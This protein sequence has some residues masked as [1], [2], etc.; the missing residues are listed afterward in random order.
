MES[1]DDQASGDEA[2]REEAWFDRAHESLHG[3]VWKTA[4]T[5]DG[6]M[7]PPLADDVYQLASGSVSA[8]VL[9]D[10]FHGF[11]ARARFNVDVPL[12]RINERLHLFVG[13]YDPDEYVTER[14][15]TLGV[16]PAPG[17]D[18]GEMDETLA[19]LLYRRDRKDGTSLSGSVGG[20]VRSG[21]PDP[22]AKVS[23]EIRRPFFDDTLATVRETVFYRVS[24]GFGS[25]TRVDLEH[26]LNPLWHLRW[27]TSGTI[28]E[29]SEGVR[30]FSTITGTRALT[31][32][33]ALVVR[34][35]VHGE[36]AAEVPLRDFGL[37]VAYRTSMIRP[38]F[39][40]ELCTSVT[41]PKHR[42][43]QSRTASLGFGVG[44]EVYFGNKAFSSRPVTF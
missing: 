30:G 31:G 37:K 22:Y 25:T 40:H 28:S 33:R 35:G 9:W 1:T 14:R 6:W 36:T 5:V 19:G 7:G 8:A 41:W 18:G 34:A 23:Y 15:D 11:D 16:I 21:N 12:P 2:V 10:E 38:W 13:R 26:V 24:E 29:K 20:S 27:T 44:C 43:S 32:R 39:V 3:L 42:L 17:S 4:R